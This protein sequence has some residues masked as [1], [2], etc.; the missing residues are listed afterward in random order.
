MVSIF[1]N[2]STKIVPTALIF[3]SAS[4]IGTYL[5]QIFI[6]KYWPVH[7]DDWSAEF[8]T[9]FGQFGLK[10]GFNS[11]FLKALILPRAGRNN[12]G[13][14]LAFVETFQTRKRALILGKYLSKIIA[15]VLSAIFDVWW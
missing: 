4:K 1:G 8:S 14:D 6:K 12:F 9:N 5:A 10:T 7:L 11:G 15:S 13:G 2:E 3:E